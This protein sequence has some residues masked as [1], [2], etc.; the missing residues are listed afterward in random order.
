MTDS[1]SRVRFIRVAGDYMKVSVRNFLIGYDPDI[2]AEG[3][4]ITVELR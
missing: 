2:P 4:S 3:V 1:L